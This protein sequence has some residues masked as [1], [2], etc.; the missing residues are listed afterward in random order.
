MSFTFDRTMALRQLGNW[1]RFASWRSL[2]ADDRSPARDQLETTEE[3]GELA[4]GDCESE[5][6]E[7]GP[8]KYLVATQRGDRWVSDRL[9][10]DDYNISDE[11]QRA[12]R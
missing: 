2:R 11:G 6:V 9:S 4:I 3:V 10:K 8:I 7:R 12:N 5:Y 1:T